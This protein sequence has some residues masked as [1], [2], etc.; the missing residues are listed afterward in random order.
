MVG[1]LPVSDIQ[2]GDKVRIVTHTFDANYTYAYGTL[3]IVSGLHSDYYPGAYDLYVNEMPMNFDEVEK[4]VEE[5]YAAESE[6]TEQ[7][8][9]AAVL[10]LM[11]VD[12][13]DEEMETAVDLA[14]LL[15]SAREA[16]EAT[17]G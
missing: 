6:M 15:G 9:V 16:K 10:R 4:V 2:V 11:G 17:N 5:D 12:V 13:S 7:A 8:T 1:C 14:I 3:H